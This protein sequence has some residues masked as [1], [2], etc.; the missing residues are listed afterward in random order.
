MRP[1]LDEIRVAD[2]G[3]LDIRIIEDDG[4]SSRPYRLVTLEPGDPAT[5]LIR[6][7]TLR[8][9]GRVLGITSPVRTLVHGGEDRFTV[10]SADGIPKEINVKGWPQ[11]AAAI[12]EIA[13]LAACAD[14][15]KRNVHTYCVFTHFSLSPVVLNKWQ[16]LVSVHRGFFHRRGPGPGDE[17]RF[18]VINR[19]SCGE[20]PHPPVFQQ[21]NR[22]PWRTKL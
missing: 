4:T 2:N 9:M 1:L 13:D 6:D 7:G 20:P 14:S 18:G 17:L 12:R 15:L 22:L 11:A 19:F 16:P 3:S 5:D 8:K 10:I 21:P